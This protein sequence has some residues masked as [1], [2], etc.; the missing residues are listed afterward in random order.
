PP[1]RR[2]AT[3]SSMTTA[4]AW[5]I[6]PTR[7]ARAI[8]IALSAATGFVTLV[9]SATGRTW[10]GRPAPARASAAGSFAARSAP[11]APPTGALP[12]RTGD[13]VGACVTLAGDPVAPAHVSS[14]VTLSFHAADGG[15]RPVTGRTIS[16]VG[17]DGA[18][19][20]IE[21]IATDSTGV[22][23]VLVRLGRRPGPE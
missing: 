12:A 4:T 6:V 22:A 1:T 17:P 5:P 14:A 2:S 15:G 9:R 16:V 11:R 3:T 7:P 20:P 21:A 18:S 23:R 10:P 13:A 19:V 8:H